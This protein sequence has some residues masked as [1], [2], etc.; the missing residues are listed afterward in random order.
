MQSAQNIKRVFKS[1]E[2][3]LVLITLAIVLLFYFINPNYLSLGSLRGTMQAMS[4]TGILAVG[5]GC[6]FIGGGIDL[7]T[8]LECLFGGVVCAMMINAGV[9]WGVAIVI[10]LFIGALIGVVNALLISKLGMMPFIATIAVSNILSGLNLALTNT[11]NVA[12]SV[13]SFWWAGKNLFG[14][15]PI[16]FVIMFMLLLIYGLILSKTQLGRNIYLV[17]GNQNAARLSG[18]NPVKVRSILYVN[19]AVLATL[20]GIVLASRMHSATPNSL[21]DAQMD[22]I[23]AVIL[24]G[25]AFTGG[26]GGMVGCFIGIL[27]LNFFN[28]GLNTLALESYWSTIASGTLLAVAL[29]V[30]FINERSREKALKAKPQTVLTGKGV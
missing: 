24:G 20:A 11:Q 3:L 1:K 9:P 15:L 17:G 23:T 14:I 30:D 29:T 16:P 22:A 4:I 5:T 28:T 12:V 25:I 26:A 10:T 2:M 18:V 8:S 27:L 6:L 19:N 13:E 7:A 21:S